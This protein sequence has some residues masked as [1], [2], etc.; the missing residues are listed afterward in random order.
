MVL[1]ALHI[2]PPESARLKP[3]SAFD[4]IK[5][6]G[7]EFG[8]HSMREQDDIEGCSSAS[9]ARAHGCGADAGKETPEQPQLLLQI[10]RM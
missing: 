4:P 9:H 8:E 3:F 10:I 6:C 7:A 1:N 5:H 2:L